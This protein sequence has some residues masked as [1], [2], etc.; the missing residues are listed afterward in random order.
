MKKTL[1]GEENMEWNDLI[2]A[3]QSFNLFDKDEII[4]DEHVHK[5]MEDLCATLPS[6]QGRY[7][8]FIDVF[9]W[10]DPEK[11]MWMYDYCTW[12]DDN[13]DNPK[14]YNRQPQMLAPIIFTFTVPNQKVTDFSVPEQD[15]PIGL[16]IDSTE[17]SYYEI[18]F[19]AMHLCHAA[20]D[21]GYHT[22]FCACIPDY[23]VLAKNIGY[24]DATTCLVLGIGTMP[25]G[26]SQKS[27]DFVCPIDNIHYKR[28]VHWNQP[29][30]EIGKFIKYHS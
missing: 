12:I 4:P 20:T 13:P 24:E 26:M 28:G 16:R 22:G 30:P 18:G 23:T 5:M 10:S 11:R 21:L 7:P 17:V 29:R 27:N 1:L 8:Y 3:R 14:P 2:Y 9:N 19:A 15:W 6:K 25:E